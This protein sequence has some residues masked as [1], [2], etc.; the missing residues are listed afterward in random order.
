MCPGGQIVPSSVNPDELCVNGMSFSKRD[1]LWANSALVVA[2]AADDPIL[3]P[4]RDEF[5][6][7]AGIAFQRDMEKRA[8]I[9][10]GGKLTVPVQ[11]LTDFVAGRA[12]TSAPSSSYRLGVKPSA[13]HE[14]YPEPLTAAL[15]DAVVN[16]FDKSLPGFLCDEGLLHAVETRTSSP[17]R[18]SRDPDTLQAIGMSRLYPAGEGAGFAG[19]IVSAAVDGIAVADAVLRELVDYATDEDWRMKSK[20]VGYS[21]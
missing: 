20:S 10:G 15:R 7:L 9:M 2:V 17:V 16:H 12:S 5:G 13:C 8:S 19:G 21:Y 14:I 3:D 4:Y 1:S 6:V 11:R 18:I